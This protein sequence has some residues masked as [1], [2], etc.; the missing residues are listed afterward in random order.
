MDTNDSFYNYGP[1]PPPSDPARDMTLFQD[2]DLSGGNYEQPVS[3]GA[4]AVSFN[5]F[6]VDGTVVN[7]SAANAVADYAEDED[8]HCFITFT[9]TDGEMTSTWDSEGVED[10]NIP[11][12]YD[13]DASNNTD[14]TYYR[15][16]VILNGVTVTLGGCFTEETLCDGEKGLIQRFLKIA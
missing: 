1:P 2:P 6:L 15:V 16:P 8:N 12:L 14:Q 3:G 10:T 7:V 4:S 13:G 5:F 11:P 9:V